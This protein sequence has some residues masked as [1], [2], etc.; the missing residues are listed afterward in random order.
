MQARTCGIMILLLC[1]MSFPGYLYAQSDLSI[2]GYI[3]TDL[4]LR[5]DPGDYTWNENRLNLKFE[6]APIEN[7]RFFSEVRLRGFGFPEVQQS[8][9]LQRREKDK[10]YPW[11]LEFREAYVDLYGF[12]LKNLDIRLGRQIIS[13]GVSDKINPTSNLCPDD[14]EDI[15]NFGELLG[16]NALKADYYWDMVT[17]TGVFVPVFT[18]ATLP[19]GDYAAAFTPEMSL[20]PGLNPRMF[21]DRIILPDNKI[22]ATSQF[23]VR[24]SSNLLNYD[25]S[26]SYFAGRDDMPLAD[27]VTITPVD[28]LG[29][30]DFA[31]EMIYPKIRALGGDFTGSIGDVG[32]WGEGAVFLPERVELNVDLLTPD[33]LQTLET[34]LALDDEPYGKYVLG[35]DYTFKSKWYLNVQFIHGFLHERGSA[36]LNDYFAFRFEKKFWNDEFK[37]VPFGGVL[38]VSD[39]ADA[40]NNYGLAGMPEITYYPSDNV[41]V[42]LGAFLM[43]GRGNNMFSRIKDQDQAYLKAKVSF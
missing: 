5:F 23:A 12:G 16:I 27:Q 18:P 41:E 20:P 4:R 21:S 37:F 29:N 15:F 13:W 30:A 40:G 42:T 11:G 3:Q 24:L 36:G 31:T 33:G 19:L 8:S 28:T 43:D 14:L 34:S 6:G 32:F 39:W 38:T 9:D 10:N 1:L 25:V 35:M 22:G 26:L 2:D 17:L 7:Y